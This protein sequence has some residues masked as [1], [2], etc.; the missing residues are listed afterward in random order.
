[1][2]VINT[3]T[4]GPVT[5]LELNNPPHNFFDV[6]SLTE[7]A[8]ALLALDDDDQCRAIVLCSAGKNFCAGGNFGTGQ[9]G[10][11]YATFS[12]QQF[13]T[14]IRQ[15]YGQAARMFGNT[16]PIVAAVQGSAT[17][18]GLGLAL[19]AD[20]RVASKQSKF[21]AN[22]TKL[23]IHTGFGAT[24]TLPR[25]IGIQ[26]AHKMLMTARRIDGVEAERIGLVDVL[27]SNE[28]IRAQ[29][30]AL[31][32]EISANAPLAVESIRAA[33]R[34]GLQAAVTAAIEVEIA[35]QSR[36]RVTQDAE[37]GIKAV[38]E[39]RPGKFNKQ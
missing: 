8:D 22:F 36:L 38:A 20:F 5:L 31:A 30:I 7:L 27:T 19:L 1:M 9:A 13:A 23:G 18:G 32:Q 24:V 25:V 28:Q 39:Q 17:G 14:G 11:G 34:E 35:E 16:K 15:V 10:S 33:V 12:K 29:A 2:T 37:E 6:H 3:Q 26:Q 4:M 21:W